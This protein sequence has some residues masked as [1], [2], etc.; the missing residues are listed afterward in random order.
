MLDL[1]LYTGNS[2]LYPIQ[3]LLNSDIGGSF[4]SVQL[5]FKKS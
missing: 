1:H 4:E 5:S 2:L 3:E